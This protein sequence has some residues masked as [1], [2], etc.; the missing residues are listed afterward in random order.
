ME[1][2]RR[3]VGTMWTVV[4]GTRMHARVSEGL[5][6]GPAVVL[7][8]GLVVSGRYMIPTLKRL[9]VHHRVYAPDLPGFGKS[10]KPARAQDVPGLSDALAGWMRNLGLERAAL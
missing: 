1:T 2:T 3:S 8:H 5:G 9:A 6:D 10:G 7:V 4:D